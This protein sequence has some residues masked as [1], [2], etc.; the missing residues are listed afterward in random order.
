MVE[1]EKGYW[2][3]SCLNEFV[4]KDVSGDYCPRCCTIKDEWNSSGALPPDAHAHWK[5]A[6]D[7]HL[8]WYKDRFK[9]AENPVKEVKRKKRFF[10]F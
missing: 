7:V 5:Y 1:V 4:H 9:K 8:I 3:C 10:L 2:A 6:N